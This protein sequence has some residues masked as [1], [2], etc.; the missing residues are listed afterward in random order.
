VTNTSTKTISSNPINST[1]VMSTPESTTITPTEQQLPI[2]KAERFDSTATSTDT[3]IESMTTATNQKAENIGQPLDQGTEAQVTAP[4]PP[5]LWSEYYS[6]RT[7][8]NLQNNNDDS[9]SST[10]LGST[11]ATPSTSTTTTTTTAINQP[12]LLEDEMRKSDEITETTSSEKVMSNESFLEAITS[13]KTFSLQPQ[14][15]MVKGVENSKMEVES[16]FAEASSV[17]FWEK[18][19]W[20][21]NIA[22]SSLTENAWFKNVAASLRNGNK[23]N[24]DKIINTNFKKQT[25]NIQII[26]DAPPEKPFLDTR[27]MTERIMKRIDTAAAAAAKI[28]NGSAA[29]ATG[30][31]GAGGSTSYDAFLKVEDNWTKLKQSSS[32]NNPRMPLSSSSTFAVQPPFVTSD[33]ALGNPKCWT[34]LRDQARTAMTST[35][36]DLTSNVKAALDYDIVVCGGTLGIFFAMA[37][38]LRNP[39]YRI[40]VVESAP[41]I[42]GRDQE[43]NISYN[44]LYELIT[45][46]ILSQSDLDDIITTEFPA[47]RSGFKVSSGCTLGW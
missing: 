32:S 14:E 19:A 15:E 12:S 42:R 38:L 9:Y 44:E 40:C 25:K 39:K 47:C 11:N 7:N 17:P 28:Q 31:G 45:L 24:D 27:G 46:G 8:G 23:T 29:A 41:A 4:S 26:M 16:S 21:K 6:N 30:S 20:F 35:T 34:K 37:L 36:T 2:E 1:P 22:E 3:K 10:H 13:M 33:A 43:W 18:N 5:S